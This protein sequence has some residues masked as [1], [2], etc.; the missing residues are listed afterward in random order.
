MEQRDDVA[1]PEEVVEGPLEGRSRL[2]HVLYHHSYL[3]RV[4]GLLL[5][6]NN[7]KE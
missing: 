3:P 4:H 7:D 5:L 1:A 6:H 2:L